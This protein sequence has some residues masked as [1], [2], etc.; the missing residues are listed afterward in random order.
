MQWKSVPGFDGHY[1]ASD[2]GLIRSLDRMITTV[3][4]TGK[5]YPQ[6]RPGRILKPGKIGVSDHLHVVLEGRVDRT[7]HALILETFVGPCPPGREALHRDDDPSNNNLSNLSWGTRSENS[8]DAIR[9]D[10]HFHAG[11]THCIRGHEFTPENMQ[12]HSSSRRR[13]CLACRRERQTVYNS[14]GRV[15]PEG[16]CP[17]GHPKTPENRITNGPGRTRCKVCATESRHRRADSR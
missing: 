15:V 8:Y 9:N 3:S 17:N 4:R 14:G 1:E 13:T 5:P 2:T 7:V 6:L 11:L 16:F 12:Q 10:R